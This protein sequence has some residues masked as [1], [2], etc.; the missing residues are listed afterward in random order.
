M[1]AGYDE[2]TFSFRAR[3]RWKQFI[4]VHET[5]GQVST[6]RKNP[7]RAVLVVTAV[8]LTLFCERK[9]ILKLSLLP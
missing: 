8:K 7:S 6:H 2:G 4:D 9:L 1:I 5:S 3:E